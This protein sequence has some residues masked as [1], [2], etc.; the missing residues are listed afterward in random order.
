VKFL[1]LVGAVTC[2]LV[3]SY[4]TIR[5][6]DP[7]YA[8]W[9]LHDYRAMAG[10]SP[11]LTAD[12]ARPFVYRILGP[13]IA[14]L[15]PFSIDTSFALLT[16]AAAISLTITFYL[17]LCA[18]QI[19]PGSAALGAIFFA[20]NKYFFG[21]PVWNYFQINDLLS[22]IE[23]VLLMWMMLRRRW[24]WFGLILL[25]S[26]M[27]REIGML[28]I[29][30]A[31]IFLLETRTAKSEWYKLLVSA[32]PGMTIILM[33]HLLLHPVSGN[34]LFGA[35]R[36]YSDKLLLPET[37]F[38]FLI[39]A[40]L[41]F[42][43]VPLVYFEEAKKYFRKRKFAGV[44]FVLILISTFFGYN[45]ERL[46]APAFIVFYPLLANI[47]DNH[48]S[49]SVRMIII[50]TAGAVL[51]NL[52]Y[53]YSRLPIPRELSVFLSLLSLTVITISVITFKKREHVKVSTQELF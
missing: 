33:L 32:L 20:L 44:Y 26:G 18:L 22:D 45:D 7:S 53:M 5:Y 52:H 46:M 35:L 49:Q 16:S 19:R 12:V 51:S 48:L 9:D 13:L 4:G 10:V 1:L 3:Y 43:L 30:I 39:N 24:L 11:G 34:D 31:G 47:L 17:Y 38:R 8:T 37:W 42:S 25:L 50:L 28:M 21:F 27:T 29:P 41:P 2:F 6:T 36:E 23:I 14:G 40:F 15:L